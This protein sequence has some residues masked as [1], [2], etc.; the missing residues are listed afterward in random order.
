[1]QQEIGNKTK[2]IKLKYDYFLY[3]ASWISFVGKPISFYNSWCT[4]H[5]IYVTQSAV[6]NA[7]N[8]WWDRQIYST[9]T[10]TVSIVA[11]TSSLYI[12]I[13]KKIDFLFCSLFFFYKEWVPFYLLVKA[14]FIYFSLNKKFIYYGWS[15][16]FHI[17]CGNLPFKHFPLPKQSLMHEMF[18][19]ISAMD[20]PLSSVLFWSVALTLTSAR[21]L[22]LI[23]SR[24]SIIHLVEFVS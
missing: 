10:T 6:H 21:H 18:L 22:P 12:N 11:Y 14:L 15:N 20:I 16:G 1:M 3:P 5:K 8:N 24:A 23:P 13:E 17:L 7:I 2:L 9:V 4:V 19:T